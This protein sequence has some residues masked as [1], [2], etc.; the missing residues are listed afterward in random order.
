MPAISAFAENAFT[1]F[2]W[3]S[4]RL[5]LIES[6]SCVFRGFPQFENVAIIGLA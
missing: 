1:K 2:P 5:L 6:G 3:G 4:T